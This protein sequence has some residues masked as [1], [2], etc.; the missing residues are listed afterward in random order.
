MEENV[1]GDLASQGLEV[2]HRD[3]RYFVR[4]DAGAH[5]VAWREDELT[6]EEFRRLR[7]GQQEEHAV[8]LGVQQ[9]ISAGGGN[10]YRENWTKV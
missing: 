1:F 10:P 5:Q 3:G 7:L 9:R 2:V 4:Y 8:L 6:A